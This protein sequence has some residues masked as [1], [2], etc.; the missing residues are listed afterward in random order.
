MKNLTSLILI[1]VAI[2]AFT[3]A[4]SDSGASKTSAK[5]VSTQPKAIDGSK[6]YKLNCTV[7]HGVNGDM[8]ASGAHDLTKSELSLDERIAVITN[9]RNTMTPF[10][11]ILSEEKIKAVAEYTM[12]LK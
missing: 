2:A 8:G 10:A 7:C 4:C 12:T 5:T 11:S 1:L 9:G 3:F 6:I